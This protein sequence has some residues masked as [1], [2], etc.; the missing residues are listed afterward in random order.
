VKW[1]RKFRDS[2][3]V[4]FKSLIMVRVRYTKSRD[5]DHGEMKKRMAKNEPYPKSP[6]EHLSI[7]QPSL[8]HN[9]LLARSQV[10]SQ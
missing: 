2:R 3:A 6:S 4:V 5:N 7:P 10:A 1:S 9:R 8:D